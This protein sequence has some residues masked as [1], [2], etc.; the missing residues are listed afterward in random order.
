MINGELLRTEI[1]NSGVSI[2]F[3]CKLIGISRQ[4]FYRKLK[5]SSDFKAS[6]ITMI[7]KA[8]HLNNKQRDQ[9]FFT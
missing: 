9:I 6:E 2:I 7:G 1:K 8:L 5:G 3:I 4:C